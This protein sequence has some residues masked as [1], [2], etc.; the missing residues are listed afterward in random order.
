VEEWAQV[1][2]KGQKCAPKIPE[3]EKNDY[4]SKENIINNTPHAHTSHIF[5]SVLSAVKNRPFSPTTSFVMGELCS[6]IFFTFF[7]F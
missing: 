5:T 6:V 7:P 4:V 2:S 3:A 1:P